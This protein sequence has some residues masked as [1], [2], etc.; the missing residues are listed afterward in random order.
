MSVLTRKSWA[1]I[2][3]RRSRSVFTVGAVAAAVVGLSMFAMPPLMD[4]AMAERI[5]ED[6]LHDVRF[7]TDNI[8]LDVDRAGTYAVFGTSLNLTDTDG[9]EFVADFCMDEPSLQVQQVQLWPQYPEAFAE[10]R[11]Q[12]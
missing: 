4:Q 9:L 5:A 1:D 12:E 7:F 3:R 11:R 2:R 6:R 10:F 8:V